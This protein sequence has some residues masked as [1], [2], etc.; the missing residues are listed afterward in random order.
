[1]SRPEVEEGTLIIHDGDQPSRQW[2]IS[3]DSIVIGVTRIAMSSCMKRR[4]G[5][6]FASSGRRSVF[7]EDLDSKNGTWVNGQPLKGSRE[8]D[9]NDDIHLAMVGKIRFIGSAPPVR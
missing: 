2:P 6:T 4:F 8:L 7:C 3:K 9:H 5:S 1:M